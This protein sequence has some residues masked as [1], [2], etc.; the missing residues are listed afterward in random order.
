MIPTSIT[1]FRSMRSAI[2]PHNKDVKNLPS[3]NTGPNYANNLKPKTLKI[4]LRL[5]TVIDNIVSRKHEIQRLRMTYLNLNKEKDSEMNQLNE[6]ESENQN[7]SDK[8]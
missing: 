6:I 8:E 4:I 7:K 5:S 2:A 1:G 3:M